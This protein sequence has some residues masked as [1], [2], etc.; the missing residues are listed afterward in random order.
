ML[1][2]HFDPASAPGFADALLHA[3]PLLAPL[4]TLGALMLAMLK[5]GR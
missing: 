3:A 5:G 1:W 2:I 4:G